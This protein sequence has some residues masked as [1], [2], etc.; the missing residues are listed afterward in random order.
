MELPKLYSKN[1][2][3]ALQ[4]IQFTP[5][6]QCEVHSVDLRYG[7]MQLS[8]SE[9]KLD[10]ANLWSTCC[11]GRDELSRRFTKEEFD[12]ALQHKNSAA[13]PD[14]WTFNDVNKLK[15]FSSD[16]VKGIHWMATNGTTPTSWKDFNSMMLLKKPSEY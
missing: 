14:G 13:G 7:L 2:K 9:E 16:F 8:S 12:V 1:T 5:D 11:E 3:K 10:V 6:K 4:K 15:N